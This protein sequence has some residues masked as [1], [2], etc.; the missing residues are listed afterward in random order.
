MLAGMHCAGGAVNESIVNSC[1]IGIGIAHIHTREFQ[2]TLIYD[3]RFPISE[4]GMV[5]YLWFTKEHMVL[6][7][8]LASHTSTPLWKAEHRGKIFIATY[9]SVIKLKL[10]S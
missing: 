2:I 1:Q 4:A 5:S 7:T 3:I 9:Y 6:C 8:T 10:E